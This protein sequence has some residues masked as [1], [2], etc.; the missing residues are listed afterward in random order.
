M[1][2]VEPLGLYMPTTSPYLPP[3]FL[4][5]HNPRHCL[6]SRPLGLVL[7]PKLPVLPRTCLV[8]KSNCMAKKPHGAEEPRCSMLSSVY[9]TSLHHG[10]CARKDWKRYFKGSVARMQAYIQRPRSYPLLQSSFFLLP[11]EWLIEPEPQHP[12]LPPA[13]G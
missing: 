13:M 6:G 9:M 4:F 2:T 1:T 10:A 8:S 5:L 11:A 3:G 12:S 7:A